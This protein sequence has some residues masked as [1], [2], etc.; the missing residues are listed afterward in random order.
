MRFDHMVTSGEIDFD[1]ITLHTK[2][3]EHLYGCHTKRTTGRLQHDT[4]KGK[5][6]SEW[7]YVFS[8]SCQYQL[9]VKD[10]VQC[11]GCGELKK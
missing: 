4:V 8:R 6:K 2:P 3:K 1:V 5:G 10:D 7:A 9:A 11:K